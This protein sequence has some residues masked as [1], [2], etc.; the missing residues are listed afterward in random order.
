MQTVK[1][2]A[3]NCSMSIEDVTVLLNDAGIVVTGADQVVDEAMEKSLTNHVASLAMQNAKRVID[4]KNIK[5]M[6]ERLWRNNP[7]LR[8]EF[9][10][11][12]G[13][14]LAYEQAYARG[15]I[16]VCGEPLE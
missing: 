2:L 13:S 16:R 1:T 5:A 6:A 11:D 3:N 4:D 8:D 9:H 15:L 14:Y 10:G 7:E 12:F